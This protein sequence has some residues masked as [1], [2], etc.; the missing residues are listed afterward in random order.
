MGNCHLISNEIHRFPSPLGEYTNDVPL[1]ERHCEWKNVSCRCWYFV[2]A[3]LSLWAWTETNIFFSKIFATYFIQSNN[4]NNRKTPRETTT[5]TGRETSTVCSCSVPKASRSRIRAVWLRAVTLELHFLAKM[6][7]GACTLHTWHQQECDAAASVEKPQ[8]ILGR[9]TL[10]ERRRE[11]YLC[12]VKTLQ[13][14][15]GQIELFNCQTQS[16]P[17]HVKAFLC[18]FQTGCMCPVVHVSHCSPTRSNHPSSGQ[19]CC[20][21]RKPGNR[22]RWISQC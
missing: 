12:S 8:R 17:V 11:S 20:T 2:E 22:M 4:N 19:T 18:C 14:S 3:F 13:H 10:R 5:A 21:F 6:A 9:C 1:L 15:K 7:A 16:L